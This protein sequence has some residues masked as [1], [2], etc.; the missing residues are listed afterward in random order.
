MRE[1]LQTIYSN[2]QVKYLLILIAA[3]LILGILSSL[4][5]RDFRLT[6]V[7][8]F[9]WDRV[10]P[11]VVGYGVVALIATVNPE[12]AVVR[13]FVWAALTAALLGYVLVNLKELGVPLPTM[14]A[15]KRVE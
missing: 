11:F 14:L 9:V 13:D 5:A 12:L 15:N 2:P 10:V 7:A 4:R 6:A 8:D 1:L 3:N